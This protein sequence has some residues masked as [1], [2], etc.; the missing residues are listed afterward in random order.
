MA[1]HSG[2]PLKKVRHSFSIRSLIDLKEDNEYDIESESVT[3]SSDSES[4]VDI[5]E[6]VEDGDVII[7]KRKEL[8]DGEEVIEH[9]DGHPPEVKIN[10]EKVNEEEDKTYKK[11]A[12]SYNALIM[13]AIK[14]SPY[15]RLTLNG[16]YEYIM[17]SFPYYKDNKQG[18][19]NS[20]RHNLSLN[21]CFIKVPRHYDD[22]GKGNYW[23]L[24]PQNS[25]DLFIGSNTGK[26]SLFKLIF[27][28]I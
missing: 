10:K 22:P 26:R 18:W 23:M 9:E 2:S 8:E 28:V 15:K 1:S 5:E 11:P 6:D 24:D 17:N 27:N 7:E 12:Y 21:K 25:G 13:M 4:D 3:K 20:I 14:S 16:I 19:Q